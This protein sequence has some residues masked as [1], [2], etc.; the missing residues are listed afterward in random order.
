MRICHACKRELETTS[1]SSGRCRHCGAAVV[2][3]VAQ[4][5]IGDKFSPQKPQA[6]MGAGAGETL[7]A[8]TIDQ[9]LVETDESAPTLVLGQSDTAGQTATIDSTDIPGATSSTPERK[10]PTVGDRSDLT[11]ELPATPDP[12]QQAGPPKKP[13]RG[14][15][16]TFESERTVDLDVP[17]ADAQHVESQWGGTFGA[18]SHQG[19]TIRQ[20]ETVTG[21][22]SSLP[23]KSRYVREKRR[24][25]THTAAAP[26]EIPDYELL[27][28]LGEGGM[29][30]V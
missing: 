3:I 30:V 28:I 16:H 21:F 11:V 26:G 27:D 22:R 14:S 10:S 1:L 23:V 7:T 15:T 6:D 2:H 9:P 29:G 5:T 20:R 4:R 12:R 8:P 17:P 19:Q 13:G 18:G 25:D 24:E